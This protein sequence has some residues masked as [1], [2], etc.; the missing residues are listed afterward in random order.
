MTGAKKK[1]KAQYNGKIS[2]FNM[3]TSG[4]AESFWSRGALKKRTPP[5]RIYLKDF[6]WTA[7]TG[8]WLYVGWKIYIHTH[9]HI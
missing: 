5:H 9:I 8:N 6:F 3:Y 7:Q 1:T 2:F 4:A